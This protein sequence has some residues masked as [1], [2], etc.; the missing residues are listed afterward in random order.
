MYCS[1]CVYIDINV[2]KNPFTCGIFVKYRLILRQNQSELEV[3][4]T[5][6]E[7]YFLPVIV[8][9][10]FSSLIYWRITVF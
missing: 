9:S 8:Q 5:I 10:L 2:C 4:R 3:N 6:C 7:I 1:T